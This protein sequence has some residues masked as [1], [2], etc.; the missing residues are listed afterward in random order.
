[1]DRL[2][3]AGGGIAD[4]GGWQQ[5][6]GAGDHA[7][8]IGENV[9]EHVLSNHHVELAGVF[10]KLHGAVVHQHILVLHVGI[11]LRQPV[12]DGAPQAG[13]FQHI[14]LVHTGHLLA[15][16]AGQLKGPAAD[17]LNLLLGIG[18]PVD[19]LHAPVRGVVPL[20]LA[21]VDAAGQLP[22]HH[23]VNALLR[24]L[25]FQRTGVRH[26]GAQGGGA[27]IGIQAQILS[28][29]QQGGLGPLLGGLVGAPLGAAHSAQQHRVAGPTLLGG[30][31]GIALPHRVGGAAAQQ[32]LLIG[33]AV[34]ELLADGLQHL[35]GL[36]HHFGADA[37]AAD[38]RNFIIHFAAPLA[39][40]D[41]SRPPLSTMPWTKA[42][43]GAA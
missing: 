8:L 35:D 32:H 6:D 12:H 37:V 20:P 38:E 27:Q 23:Q 28:D 7:R 5:A 15:A 14:G 33:E 43:R 9:A 21:E 10:H 17:A 13:G 25:P 1:M 39:F 40:R 34:A 31:V 3:E 4:G 11:L 19:A 29:G 36:P 24:G 30:A 22:H 41:L 16:E 42:G 18:H 2:V 26:S